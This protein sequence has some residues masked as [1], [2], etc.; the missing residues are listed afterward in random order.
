MVLFMFVM[1]IG[2]AAS[3]LP[4]FLDFFSSFITYSIGRRMHGREYVNMP[5]I[6]S[7][8]AKGGRIFSTL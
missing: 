8:L 7:V 5:E 4:Y 6:N 2:V 3:I 1:L